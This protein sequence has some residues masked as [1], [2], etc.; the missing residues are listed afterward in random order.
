MSADR[1]QIEALERAGA[2]RLRL[3]DANP[4]DTASA[5]AARLLEALA[6]DLRR[7]DHAVLWAE[8]Q[9]LC[10]W[11]AESDAISDFADL[12]MDYRARIGVS[13]MPVDGAAYLRGLLAIART[14]VEA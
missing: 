2:W 13:E 11:L 7:D 8:L 12:A 1:L 3:L 9:A 10:N 4:A 14:L 5:S 6:A